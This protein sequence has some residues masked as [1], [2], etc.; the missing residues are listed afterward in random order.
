[1]TKKNKERNGIGM[2]RN[3]REGNCNKD[4]DRQGEKIQ[5]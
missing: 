1:M 2:K 4:R 5:Q 3:K